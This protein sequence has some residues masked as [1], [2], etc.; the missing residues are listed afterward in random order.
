MLLCIASSLPW[1]VPLEFRLFLK[2]YVCP[3]FRGCF[4]LPSGS[5]YVEV[6]CASAVLWLDILLTLWP[7]FSKLDSLCTLEFT[8]DA[9]LPHLP[10]RVL[11]FPGAGCL[12]RGDA[13]A[14]RAFTGLVSPPKLLAG[15][16][17]RTCDQAPREKKSPTVVLPLEEGTQSGS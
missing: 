10:A 3:P 6:L 15:S 2:S 11:V 13:C 9:R 14:G 7:L 12:G 16:A 5:P 4:F 1:T 8:V 17:F